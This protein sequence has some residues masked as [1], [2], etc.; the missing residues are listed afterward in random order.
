MSQDF[1]Y[2]MVQAD[3]VL[4]NG[5]TILHAT[6]LSFFVDAKIGVIGHNGAGKSTVLRILAGLDEPTNGQI[7][8][9]PGERGAPG[10]PHRFA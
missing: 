3:K 4:P 9:R 7:W 8:L 10:C 6:S 5:R 1:I 2:Q